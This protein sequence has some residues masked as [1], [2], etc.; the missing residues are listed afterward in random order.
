MTT[1]KVSGGRLSPSLPVS[2]IATGVSSAVVTVCVVAVTAV[3][4]QAPVS[5][6][7]VRWPCKPGSVLVRVSVTVEEPPAGGLVTA[8]PRPGLVADGPT[9]AYRTSAPDGLPVTSRPGGENV[10]ITAT[11][12]D[13]A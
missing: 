9:P 7:L 4:G 13:G 12:V 8:G 1:T 11:L 5:S 3:A 6:G 2:V 10:T